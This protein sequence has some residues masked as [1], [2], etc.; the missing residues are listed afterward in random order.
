MYYFQIW[1]LCRL[2]I[3]KQTFITKFVIR[4]DV[5]W[6]EPDNRSEFFKNFVGNLRL[7]FQRY[8]QF[9]PIFKDLKKLVS[10]HF[11]ASIHCNLM[12][13]QAMLLS[14][15]SWWHNWGFFCCT[16]KRN[17][18]NTYLVVLL[19]Y[20]KKPEKKTRNNNS[21]ISGKLIFFSLLII[22]MWAESTV[23]LS[24]F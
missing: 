14:W 5:Q 10:V 3:S 12:L 8:F 22:I 20:L 21:S 23:F 11:F 24:L 1:L 7:P 4:H 2:K 19:Y 15:Q 17:W 13:I 16:I 6:H 9:R 18:I